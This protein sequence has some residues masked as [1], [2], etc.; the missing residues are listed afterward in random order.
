MN[1]SRDLE[2]VHGTINVL[3]FMFLPEHG[4]FHA[5][6]QPSDEPFVAGRI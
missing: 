1:G 5:P 4:S 6:D 3:D 2:G